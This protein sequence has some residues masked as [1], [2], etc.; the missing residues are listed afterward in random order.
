MMK[1]KK[2]GLDVITPTVDTQAQNTQKP[3]PTPQSNSAMQEQMQNTMSPV[4]PTANSSSNDYPE[5]TSVY[6]PNPQLEASTPLAEVHFNARD[7]NWDPLSWN[8]SIEGAV[9]ASGSESNTTFISPSF[10]PK[11]E[12]LKDGDS[13]KITATVENTSGNSDTDAIDLM[14]KGKK[15]NGVITPTPNPEPE[16]PVQTPDSGGSS[17]IEHKVF[18]NFDNNIN[19]NTNLDHIGAIRSVTAESKEA[20]DGLYSTGREAKHY[21][22]TLQNDTEN[23]N[24]TPGDGTAGGRADSGITH[25]KTEKTGAGQFKIWF[26]RAKGANTYV[27]DFTITGI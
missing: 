10:S 20:P 26:N 18:H 5:I 11:E 19:Q 25:A 17:G 2:K 16:N 13:V 21:T 27:S 24:I 23:L 8:Y 3:T 4:T 6:T 9:S 22:V 14:I 12:N 1:S 7:P 15:E